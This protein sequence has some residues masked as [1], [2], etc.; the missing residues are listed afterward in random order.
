MARFIH[1][2]H[3]L[4]SRDNAWPG[5]ATLTI[6]PDRRIGEDGKP[7]NSSIMHLPNHFGTHMDAPHHF[8]KDGIDMVD[9]PVETFGYVED[10]ILVV[11]LPH[12]CEPAAVIT[13]EDLEPFAEQIRGKGILL[14]RTGYEKYKFTDPDRYENKTLSLHPDLSRWLVEEFPEL[15]CIGMDWLS[16]ASPT[17]NYGVDAHQW[18]LGEHT[19]NYICAIEDLS[20]AELGDAT[21]KVL[22]LGPLRVRGVDSAQVNVMALIED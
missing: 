2:S 18:L 1:L 16:I 6:E 13:N 9:V 21:I 4:D 3:V 12:R 17:N 8:C 11:D 10:E 14:M 15:R 5:E 22:T 19:E 20:L 7:F